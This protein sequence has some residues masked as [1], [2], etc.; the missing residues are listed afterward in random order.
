MIQ[1]KR[2]SYKYPKQEELV[3]KDI[4]L[5]ASQALLISGESGSGKSTLLHL[6]SGILKPKSGKILID[7]TELSR[8]KEYQTDRYRGKNI[9]IV[10]QK[11]A[12]IESFSVFGNIEFHYWLATRKKVPKQEIFNILVQLDIAEQANKFP[13]NLSTG[14]RQRAAIARAIIN[15]PKVLLVDEPT[16]SLD[17]KN[18]H[19]VAGLLLESVHE[20]ETSLIVVTHDDRLKKHFNNHMEL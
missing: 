1:T 3:F 12:F 9:G 18:S 17:N 14:Q 11:P 4:S 15:N 20:L 5:S 2:I 10:F 13:R 6:L 16:S 19:K 8:L 7:N